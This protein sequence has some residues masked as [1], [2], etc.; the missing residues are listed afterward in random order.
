MHWNARKSSRL[1]AKRRDQ[2]EEAARGSKIQFDLAFQPFAQQLG[3]LVVQPAAAH[4]DGFEPRHLRFPDGRI[5]GLAE[6]LIVLEH[7]M[8]W[9]EGKNHSPMILAV[10]EPHIEDEP[11]F[12]SRQH[13]MIRAAR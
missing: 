6:G 13:E 9:R 3:A 10:S 11:R 12:D 2:G 7:T 1:E 8:K 4:V 5:I